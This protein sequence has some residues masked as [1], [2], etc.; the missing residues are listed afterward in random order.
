[1]R[2]GLYDL[3]FNSHAAPSS[4][5]G[6]RIVPRLACLA[7]PCLAAAP[8][9]A[10]LENYPRL[11]SL[12]VLRRLVE[13]GSSASAHSSH[14][15]TYYF[16]D[17]GSTRRCLCLKRSRAIS[18]TSFSCRRGSAARG[19]LGRSGQLDKPQLMSASGSGQWGCRHLLCHTAVLGVGN[20]NSI[21]IARANNGDATS[22]RLARQRQPA[23]ASAI[24]TRAGSNS[25]VRTRQRR[26]MDLLSVLLAPFS[27]IPRPRDP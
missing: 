9:V 7:L 21:V 10:L 11:A 8:C 4:C 3:T 14:T 27:P 25:Q 6:N 24:P 15:T 12:A 1:M 2:T 22:S 13:P 19:R 18:Q 5:A 20:R 16:V 17:G 26:G 23:P